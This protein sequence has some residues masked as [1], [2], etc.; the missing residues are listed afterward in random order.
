MGAGPCVRVQPWCPR[1]SWDRIC[2]VSPGDP[3]RF[4]TVT[5]LLRVLNLGYSLSMGLESCIPMESCCYFSYK[6]L[7]W[8]SKGHTAVGLKN[9]GF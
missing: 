6:L 3:L 5:T 2:C 1:P 7:L 9:G 8:R 4:I